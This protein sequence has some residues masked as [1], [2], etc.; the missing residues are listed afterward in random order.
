MDNRFA[1][2]GHEVFD[3]ILPVS[4]AQFKAMLAPGN[5]VAFNDD[6]KNFQLRKTKMGWLVSF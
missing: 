1:A 4:C 3:P 6:E 5:W 2:V